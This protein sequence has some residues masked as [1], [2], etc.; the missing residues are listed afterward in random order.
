MAN[1]DNVK[2]SRA[3]YTAGAIRSAAVGTTLPTDA[4]TSLSATWQDWGFVADSGFVRTI[5][6]NSTKIK[7]MNG[8][9]ILVVTE[10]HSLSFK[11]K[12]AEINPEALKV[13][14]GDSNVTV[15]GNGVL[16]SY[17]INSDDL[18]PRSYVFNL[19]LT[20]GSLMRIV[21][22][23]GAVDTIGD[24]TMKPNELLSSELTIECLP[25]ESGNKAYIYFAQAASSVANMNAYSLH[26]LGMDFPGVINQTTGAVSV[27]VPYGTSTSALVATFALATGASA[28]IGATAQVSGTTPN[29]FGSAKTYTITAG[30]GV[31]TKSYEVTV[32]VASNS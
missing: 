25:D 7:D 31:T 3:N 30:D 2:A 11:F 17:V 9:P 4:S 22:P 18:T 19:R 5:N 27:T 1:T 13:T 26:A 6:R 21:C 15:D 23:K 14:L 10:E 8:D 16:Q 29:N 12:P 20:D 32:T 24:E 28:K